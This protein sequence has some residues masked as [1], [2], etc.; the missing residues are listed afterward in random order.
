MSHKKIPRGILRG[1]KRVTT[2]FTARRARV[3]AFTRG[4]HRAACSIAVNDHEVVAPSSQPDAILT[5]GHHDM[6]IRVRKFTGIAARGKLGDPGEC[7]ARIEH[8]DSCHLGA[9]P[10][11]V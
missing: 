9:I 3:N 1:N 6:V 8:G 4:I 10:I 7:P 2:C 11:K 5:D